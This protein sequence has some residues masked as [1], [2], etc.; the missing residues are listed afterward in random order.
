[1]TT[2]ITYPAD[3]GL[4]AGCV[5]GLYE[6][7]IGVPDLEAAVD[8][9]AA[10]GCRPGARGTLDAGAAEALYGHPSALQ[11]VQLLHGEADHGLVR[12]MQWE[13]PRNAGVGL[14]RDLRGIGSRWGV[15]VTQS[16]YGIVNHAERALQQGAPLTLI[17]PQLAVIGEVSGVRTARP[18]R[19][20]IVG[21]REMVLLQPYYRQ[22]LFERFGYESP[23]YGQVDPASLLRTSQHTHA[24]LMI[25]SDD[26]RVFDFYDGVLGLKR[27]H[28]ETVPYENAT[29]ARRIFGLAPGEGFHMVDFDDPRTGSA[30]A[31]RRSGKLKCVRFAAGAALDDLS[32]AARPGSLGPCLYTW[33]A[34]DID[35]LHATLAAAPG[36]TRLRPVRS[37]EFGRR[38]L[39]F[40]APDGYDWMLLQA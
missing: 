18:F 38:S 26:P 10:Y 27:T 33:R 28:E 34:H 40:R 9:L 31:T 8:D 36:V 11:S 12:L 30:L 20:P 29:G 32:D 6:L 35:G 39:A 15:R 13:T 22:V 24:G 23:L 1:M 16:V 14:R 4:R 17:P 7:C 3:T 25:A 21:V 5:G 37:D 19:D 2:G